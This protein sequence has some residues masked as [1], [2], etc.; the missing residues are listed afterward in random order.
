MRNNAWND[1]HTGAA[2]A[3]PGQDSQTLPTFGKAKEPLLAMYWDEE[4]M[5]P[6]IPPGA[7]M[8]PGTKVRAQQTGKV[9]GRYNLTTRLWSGLAGQWPGGGLAG[10]TPPLP[11]QEADR[12]PTGNVGVLGAVYPGFDADVM[13]DGAVVA[14]EALTCAASAPVR[15]ISGFHERRI[16]GSS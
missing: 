12:F 11:V 14:E 2:G 15:Q 5:V 6:V 1:D 7:A 10:A 9:P 13:E 3:A 16:S 4:A 8:Q